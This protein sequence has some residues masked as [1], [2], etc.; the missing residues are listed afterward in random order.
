LLS[1]AAETLLDLG[2]DPERLGAQLGVTAVLHTWRRD[3]GWHPHVHCIVSG[4]GL[5]AC[6]DRW[7]AS[8]PDF[9]FPVRV[10]GALFRG[11]MIAALRR[12]LAAGKIDLGEA[13]P[14]AEALF[15]KLY[16][17]NWVVYAKRPFGGAEQVIRYLGRYTHRVAISNARIE[18]VSPTGV[19]FR[20]KAG[21]RVVLAPEEFLRRFLLHVLPTGFTKIRHYGLYAGG[22]VHG[23]LERARA[24]LAASDASSCSPPILTPRSATEMLMALLGV[25]PNACSRCGARALLPQPLPRASTSPPVYLD[26]S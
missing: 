9:L 14:D 18:D 1:C 3:L 24:L 26:T 20:T 19:R 6:R 8:K 2:R 23:R 10:M 17:T 15:A 7:V 13:E 21:K 22:N 11:K 25:D 4:G 12:A 5:D 16:A